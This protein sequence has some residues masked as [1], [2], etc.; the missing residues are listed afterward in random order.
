MVNGSKKSLL[1][2][3]LLVLAGAIMFLPFLGKVHLFDWDE[4]N[5]AECAR[6]MIAAKQYFLVT[7][8]YLPFWE[9]PPLFIWMQALS[10]K[11]FGVSDYAA[12]FP[13]ALCGIATMLVLYNIGKLLKDKR[14]GLLWVL[15]YVG[16]LLPH[17]YFKSGIIDPWFNLFI[18]SGVYFFMRFQMQKKNIMQGSKIHLVLSAFCIGLAMLTKGPVAFLIFSLTTVIYWWMERRWNLI[19]FQQA[20]IYLLVVVAAGGAWFASEALTG[21]W[22]TIKQFI[23]YQ[24]RLFNTQDSGHGGPFY[25]HFIILLI[26][27]FPAS[28]FAIGGMMIKPQDDKMREAARWMG[29]L[30]WVVL[31]LFSIVK[32]KILHYS[33]L[34]YYPLTFFAALALYELFENAAIWKKWMGWT[35]GIL[36]GVLVIALALLPV[37]GMNKQALIPY[38]KDPFAVANLDANVAW[39]YTDSI[40]GFILLASLISGFIFIKRG[41]VALGAVVFF[42]GTLITTNS[43]LIIIAPKI[44]QITQESAIDFYQSLKGK[45]VYV[46]TID[47]KSYAHYFYTDEQPWKDSRCTDN[48]WLLHGNIDKSAYFV[49]KINRATDIEKENPQLKELYRKNGFV[50]LQRALSSQ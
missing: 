44:E 2:P 1:I 33:S 8:N 6:E 22:D 3:V 17:F 28:I 18:F 5:F 21:H 14:F 7:I 35:I 32:T 37:A 13:N 23:E 16:S 30:F 50:F 40:V 11:L 19:N 42:V 15:V 4:I 24:I 47:F 48:D 20:V 25:Y 41:K 9:K 39:A 27:C 38:I 31:I 49:C 34:C 26:G 46:T 29:I 12:R 10:M 43:A 45:D 36:G